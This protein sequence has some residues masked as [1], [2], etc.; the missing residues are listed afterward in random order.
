MGRCDDRGVQASLQKNVDEHCKK[1]GSV[2]IHLN[3]WGKKEKICCV[4]L[5]LKLL[6]IHVVVR[7]LAGKSMETANVVGY[8]HKA[9]SLFVYMY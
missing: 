4:W 8:L 9:N 5:L 6:S 2:N 7:C 3:A 1:Q